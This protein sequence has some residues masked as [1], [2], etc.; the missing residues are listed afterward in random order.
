MN[1]SKLPSNNPSKLPSINPSK[2]PSMNP[3]KLPYISSICKDVDFAN[4]EGIK[5]INEWE[6]FICPKLGTPNGITAKMY[7]FCPI[8]CK[9]NCRQLLSMEPS[10]L[11]SMD[12]SKLPSMDPSKPPS[13]LPS[14]N[15]TKRVSMLPSKDP[16]KLY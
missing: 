11:P 6:K 3:S 2:L 10:T 12:P 5:I 16:S 15:P 4:C 9:V 8:T 13:M 7:I 1:P 14:K